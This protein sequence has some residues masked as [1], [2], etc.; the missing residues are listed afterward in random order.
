[1]FVILIANYTIG[2]LTIDHFHENVDQLYILGDSD[3]SESF[4]YRLG[5]K[6]QSRY[7]EI[8]KVCGVIDN[9]NNKS[10]E[11]L[12]KSYKANIIAVDTTFFDMFSFELLRGD[13]KSVLTSKNSVVI[14]EQLA[15]KIFGDLDPIGQKILVAKNFMCSVSGVVANFKDTSLKYTDMIIRMDGMNYFSSFALSETMN[16]RCAKIFIETVKGSDIASKAEDMTK[17]LKTFY[18]NHEDDS[19]KYLSFTLIKD[20]Y[21]S[22]SFENGKG[23]KGDGFIITLLLVIGSL[24]LIFAIFN[25]INLTVAQTG[26]RAKEMSTRRLLGASK[27]SIFIKMVFESTLLCTL[28]FLIAIFLVITIEPY[29]N[30]LLNT[31]INLIEDTSSTWMLFYAG[32][33]TIL[34]FIT[35]LLP[36]IVIL[37]FKPID[38]VNGSFMFKN[39]M[40]Y[41]KVFIIIQ[42]SITIVLIASLITVI[43][44]VKYMVTA[45]LGYN[46]KG[47]ISIVVMKSLIDEN[48]LRPFQDRLQSLPFVRNVGVTI[49]LPINSGLK[50]GTYNID[51]IGDGVYTH[52][53]ECDS[54]AMKIFGIKIIQDN[55]AIRDGVYLNETAMKMLNV[56]SGAKMF[57]GLKNKYNE[58]DFRIRGIL[59]DFRMGDLVLGSVKPLVLYL[60]ENMKQIG[61]LLVEVDGD[62]IESYMEI[63]KVYKEFVD[64]DEVPAQFIEQQV[65]ECYAKYIR[66]SKII[67]IFTLIAIIISTLGLLAMSAYFIRQRS[68]EIAVRKVFG[69]TNTQ[70][71]KKL[72]W[73]FLRLVVVAFFIACPIIWYVMSEWLKEFPYRINL[74]VWIF[75]AAGAFTLLI[76]FITVYWHSSI[77]ANENPTKSI[78]K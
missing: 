17:Y 47:I 60:N 20:R 18:W 67:S 48:N 54:V 58:G 33:I 55:Q 75:L 40:I 35:G 7:P 69:S 25:Y 13:R 2:E 9:M 74:S 37:K 71:L 21:F 15:N 51:G 68:T 19:A 49:G 43:S 16:F 65:V 6:L 78:K 8:Y 36:A 70:V 3:K 31:N 63:T 56:K 34:G 29:A 38:V 46:Q 44:Q 4:G 22:D 77:A 73:Q 28:S 42:S 45:D 26:F 11:T 50:S 52:I 24:I 10:V 39:K 72:V 5:A 14:S 62:L 61:Q 1:M 30:K 41:S 23:R 64:V 32:F 57:T 53:L 27:Q 12:N 66:L 76:S 59:K